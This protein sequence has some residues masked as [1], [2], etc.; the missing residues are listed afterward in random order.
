M[1]EAVILF[2]V[3]LLL[4]IMVI[5]DVLR[6]TAYRWIEVWPRVPDSYRV[7][8]W[9]VR[10]YGWIS[11]DVLRQ[12]DTDSSLLTMKFKWRPRR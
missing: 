5:A 3:S 2:A 12:R 8:W 1:I 7:A 6:Q 11:F 4:A 10:K 9:A